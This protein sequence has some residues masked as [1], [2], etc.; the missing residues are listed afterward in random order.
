MIRT[1]RSPANRSFAAAIAAGPITKFGQQKFKLAMSVQIAN[2]SGGKVLLPQ[3]FAGH[4]TFMAMA[5]AEAG[6]MKV[7]VSKQALP[8]V[9]LKRAHANQK[10]FEAKQPAQP[11]RPK[12]RTRIGKTGRKGGKAAA[13]ARKAAKREAD[14]QRRAAM[15]GSSSKKK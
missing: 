13:D 5:E 4:A 6:D 9:E 8:S 12:S 11:E 14:R 7:V 3:D 1:F 10:A 15:K 2:A